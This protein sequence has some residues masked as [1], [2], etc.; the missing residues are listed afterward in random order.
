[1]YT[2]KHVEKRQID[3]KDKLK[4]TILALPFSFTKSPVFNHSNSF[5]VELKD[6]LEL[7]EF[8]KGIIIFVLIL[9]LYRTKE[10]ALADSC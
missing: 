10:E 8:A 5:F 3:R 7:V 2:K 1:M 9:L 4:A 6:S